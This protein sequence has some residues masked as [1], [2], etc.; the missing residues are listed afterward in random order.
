MK[1]AVSFISRWQGTFARSRHGVQ[2]D[3]LTPVAVAVGMV[4]SEYA[5]WTTGENIRPGHKRVA[6][7]VG[8]SLATVKRSVSALESAGW[9]G[10]DERGTFGRASVYRLTIPPLVDTVTGEL[11]MPQ[12]HRNGVTGDPVGDAAESRNGVI[13]A[14]VTGSPVTPHLYRPVVRRGLGLAA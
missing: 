6:E 2:V 9:L 10:C 3:G 8:T 13:W 1:A 5:D 14:Y 12:A 11:S 4:M 7:V